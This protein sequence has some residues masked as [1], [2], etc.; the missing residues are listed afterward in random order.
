L[1][2]PPERRTEPLV[3]VPEADRVVRVPE[4]PPRR[5][6]VAAL[7]AVLVAAAVVAT[8]ITTYAIERRQVTDAQRAS[9]ASQV[10]AQVAQ[11]KAHNSVTSIQTKISTVTAQL[12]AQ[13]GGLQ[14]RIAQARR[15][16]TLEASVQHAAQGTARALTQQMLAQRARIQSITG[17]PLANGNYVA[18][19]DAVGA[20]QSPPL[21]VLDP[22]HLFTGKEAQ[23]AAIQD[24]FIQ[25]GQT[26]PHGRYFRNPS[27]SWRIMPLS[28]SSTLVIRRG[29]TATRVTLP[30]L[31]E[32]FASP[33]AGDQRVT[34]DP[35]VV[36]V[37]GGRVTALKELLYP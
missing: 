13:I 6:T 22:V 25:P 11:A 16:A 26:L 1:Q 31:Q 23:R 19:I 32:I 30:S 21:V 17:A 5:S 14:A 34:L 37:I 18:L 28:V 33:E 9:D 4:Y 20:Q 35:F 2:T 12:K 10:A 27:T 3:V 29:K 8:A 7:V 36:T 24:G 15:S